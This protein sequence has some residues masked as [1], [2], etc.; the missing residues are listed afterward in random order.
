M[1]GN[2]A[3]AGLMRSPGGTEGTGGTGGT[4]GAGANPGARGTVQITIKGEK[5]GVFKGPL[6]HGAIEASKFHMGVVSP[7]DVATGQ[8]SGRRLYKAITFKK[9]LDATS[10]QL[11][12]ALATNETLEVRI[13]FIGGKTSTGAAEGDVETIVIKN[14]SVAAFDQDSDDGNSTDTV[15][16]TYQSIEMRNEPGKTTA[17]DQWGLPQAP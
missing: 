2:R 14:V 7:H 13:E 1:A 10:P 3:V 15:S 9:Q 16:L 8:A 4:G 6:T 11:L 17:N 5:Q 12:N